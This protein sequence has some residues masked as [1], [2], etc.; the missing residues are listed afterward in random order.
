MSNEEIDTQMSKVIKQRVYAIS[1]LDFLF[2]FQIDNKPK[3][4]GL[5]LAPLKVQQTPQPIF[6]CFLQLKFS[7]SQ[8][9]FFKKINNYGNI[10]HMS[11]TTHM[12]VENI[13]NILIS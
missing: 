12:K 2:L 11:L 8:T 6:S 4:G 7:I 5:Q 9:L 3:K 1:H 13:L 10:Y